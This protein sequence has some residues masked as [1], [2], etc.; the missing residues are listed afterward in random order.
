MEGKTLVIK[1]VHV[2]YRLVVDE[3]TDRHTVERV[4]GF[5][6]QHCPVFRSIHPQITCTTSVEVVQ[7]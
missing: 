7:D 5:H 6:A 1:R 3:E 4:H 2:S